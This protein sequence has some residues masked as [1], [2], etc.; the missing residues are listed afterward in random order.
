MESITLNQRQ[1]RRVEIIARVQSRGL[2]KAEAAL[3][4]GVSRRQVHNILRRFDDEGLPSVVHGNAG[5]A[6]AWKTPPEVTQ[7]IVCAAGAGGRYHDFSV[8][9]LHDMLVQCEGI[10]IGRSTLD[11]LLK[12]HGVRKARSGKRGVYRSRRERSSQEGLLLQIDGSLHAWLEGRGPRMTLMGAVDDATGKI[13]FLEF[14]PTECQ[15]GY[16][17]M[18]RQIAVTHGLPLGYY[19]DR[20]TMLQSPKELTI[21][22]ELAGKESLSQ[23]QQVLKRLGVQS[24]GAHSPQAK[25]RI[26]RLWGSLQQR[27]VKEMRLAGVNTLEAA[28]AFLPAFIPRYNARFAKQPADPQTLWVPIAP[29]TDLD[30]YFSTHDTR[31]VSCD[32]TISW[33]GRI[34]QILQRPGQ[35]G[36]ARK[37]ITVAL[38]PEG[39]V[40]LY[41]DK[42][43]LRCQERSQR[44]QPAP[45]A[46][47][48][49]AAT[50]PK[51]R[52]PTADK[53]RRAWLFGG[54]ET[55]PLGSQSA[56]GQL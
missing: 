45:T 13:L 15:A 20:H 11:R 38:T 26:E 34:F 35:P 48:H 53:R 18:F 2:S 22:E 16:L 42:N 40:C 3:H 33:Q 41:N 28:N 7:T 32:H 30:Y 24:I 49:A 6:P 44:P 4:L 50:A 9:H 14:W 21:E 10:T 25:G 46:R 8:S 55:A 12:E 29:D 47:P 54:T 31:V 23:I 17:R 43:R 19:H 39:A 37:T 52:D 1:R 27:L 5:R 56:T 51:P 36:F